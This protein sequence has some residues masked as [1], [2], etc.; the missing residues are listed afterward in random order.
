VAQTLD[1]LQTWAVADNI[2]VSLNV[3]LSDGQSMVASRFAYPE[4]P[5]SLYWLRVDQPQP[6]GVLVASE[7]LDVDEQ[8]HASWGHSWQP[9]PANTLLTIDKT[10]NV[11]THVL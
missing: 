9:V 1:R 10:G 11:T 8:L 2:R 7:P 6:V 3:I 4:D 5:P